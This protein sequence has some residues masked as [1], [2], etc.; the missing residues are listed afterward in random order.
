MHP[1]LTLH[2]NPMCAELI[3]ALVKCHEDGGYWGRLTGQCNEQKRLLD[4]CFKAQKKV[5]R[6]DHLNEARASR[7]HRLS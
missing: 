2:N 4:A 3:N 7:A 1:Q 6:K 5:K